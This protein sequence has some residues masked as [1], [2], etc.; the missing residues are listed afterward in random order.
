MDQIADFVQTLGPEVIYVLLMLGI[1]LAI[2]AIYIPGTGAPEVLAVVSL[3]AAGAGLLFIPIN[4]GALIL[5]LVG[6]GCL[7]AIIFYRQYWI[8]LLS[9]GLA[10][11]IAGS[12][13]LFK[14][15]S[16]P[17]I[18]VIGLVFVAAVAYHQIVLLPG[19]L[20]Q[21]QDKKLDADMLVGMIAEVVTT[22]DPVGTI[23]VNGELWSARAD[24]V[25]VAGRQVRI[26]ARQGLQLTV[27]DLDQAESDR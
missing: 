23:R 13:L 3:A 22:L 4:P 9:T 15:G 14:V 8:P 17:D 1:W 12:V 7:L 24:K 20:I 6:G 5:V 27:A 21:N 18:W 19:L 25:I 2:T 16:R 11:Q 10:F 26:S